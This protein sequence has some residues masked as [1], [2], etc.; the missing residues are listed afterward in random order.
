MIKLRLSHRSVRYVEIVWKR[1][2]NCNFKLSFAVIVSDVVTMLLVD[3]MLVLPVDVDIC[4]ETL[5]SLLDCEVSSIVSFP[6][7]GTGDVFSLV[8]GGKVLVSSK[9]DSVVFSAK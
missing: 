7:K 8:C 2:R 6:Y 5:T 1:Q 9:G 3:K 4:F